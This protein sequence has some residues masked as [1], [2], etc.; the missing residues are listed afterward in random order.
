MKL[1]IAAYCQQHFLYS[2]MAMMLVLIVQYVMPAMMMIRICQ[3]SYVQTNII[4]V[5]SAPNRIYLE[6][7]IKLSAHNVEL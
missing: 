3:S 4:I 2:P 1:R 7:V 6:P 5:Y